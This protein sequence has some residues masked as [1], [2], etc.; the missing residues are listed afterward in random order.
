MLQAS[1]LGLC[2]SRINIPLHIIAKFYVR[3]CRELRPMSGNF[4]PSPPRSENGAIIYWVLP[5][6]FSQIIRVPKTLCLR[7]FKLLNNKHI[8]QNFWDTII[9]LNI[10]QALPTWLSMLYLA[11]HRRRVHVFLYQCPTLIF[12]TS[13]V[14][15]FFQDDKYVDLLSQIHS[16]PA[17][18]PD[19]S[20]HKDF[21]IRQGHIWLPF[22]TPF[23]DIL[24]EEFHSSP[25]GGHTSISKTLNRLRQNF[26]WPHIH[27]DVRRYVS[28]CLTCQQTKYETK[29]IARLLHP[30]PIP[31]N[32]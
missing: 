29:K 26:D 11:S 27:V 31:S 22:P 13:F 10:N 4:T 12:W 32:M 30:L 15:P 23:T 16:S 28:W 6:L 20:L 1:P 24:L 7:W 2:W 5:S 18:H 8:Y 25:L 19:L 3:D 14:P 17:S 21:I 9:W